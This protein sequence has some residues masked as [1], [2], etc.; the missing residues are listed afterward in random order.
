MFAGFLGLAL[1]LIAAMGLDG[2]ERMA[3]WQ[4][5]GIGAILLAGAA[6]ASVLLVRQVIPGSRRR[7]PEKTALTILGAGVLA[8]IALLFPWQPERQFAE[9]G[10]ACTLRGLLVAAPAAVLFGILIWRGAK[11]SLPLLGGT[12]GATA[13][14]VG[15]TVLQF[16]C[17]HQEALH[18]LVWHA[19]V[20]VIS[21]ALGAGAGY[22]CRFLSR[23]ARN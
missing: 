22:I 6:M 19:S 11:L 7:I 8:G 2:F 23:P 15:V 20:P 13:G 12:L 9:I 10:S 1:L 4:A 16:R 17:I 5:W 21:A 3:A 14:L 18:L